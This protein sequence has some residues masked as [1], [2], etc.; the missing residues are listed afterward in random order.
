M[1]MAFSQCKTQALSLLFF[2]MY[3]TSMIG[4]S[5]VLFTNM[6][7]NEMVMSGLSN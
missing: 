6:H 7:K 3:L 4:K 5:K 2:S 1:I